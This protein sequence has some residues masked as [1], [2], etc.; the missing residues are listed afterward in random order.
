MEIF[1]NLLR[2]FNIQVVVDVR[3]YPYS[4]YVSHFNRE[5]LKTVLESEG[6]EYLWMGDVLG[7]K[8][9]LGKRKELLKED[10]KIDWEKVK[11]QDFFIN[12]IHRLI[13]VAREKVTAI[14]CAEEN[15]L[16]CHRFFLISPALLEMGVEVYHIRKNGEAQPDFSLRKK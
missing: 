4:K 15:P 5:N 8:F 12:A 13:D 1:L 11:K 14:M 2:Q 9:S 10:G 7:G 6:I 3:S 16:R